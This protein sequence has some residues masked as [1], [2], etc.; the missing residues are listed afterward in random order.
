MLPFPGTIAIVRY[1]ETP[2]RP[3]S[4]HPP[5]GRGIPDSRLVLADQADIL[6]L[7]PRWRPGSANLEGLAAWHRA[8]GGGATLVVEG[9]RWT[10]IAAVDRVRLP[11]LPYDDFWNVP[12]LHALG[13]TRAIE[14]PGT[15]PFGTAL[16]D[17]D[18]TIIED[19]DYLADPEGVSLLPGAVAGLQSF[20]A[21]GVRL[22]VLT[23]QSGVG[24]GRISLAQL[25]MVH[26]RLRDLL[27]REGVTLD[28]IY[29]CIHPSDAGCA[30]RKPAVGLVQQAVA[31]LGFRL[32]QAVVAGDKPADLALARGLGVPAFLVATGSGLTTLTE[33][34][35][36]ADYVVDGLDELA[37]I[38]LHPAGLAVPAPCP[39]D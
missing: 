29:S 18:G 25:D 20:A 19:R 4:Q 30:C 22:V 32:D 26:D 1:P 16:L 39:T 11:G 15:P 13:S 17:R 2:G 38:C 6:L 28:G 35:I 9:S 36:Q 12:R 5:P 3:E 24:S 34:T 7:V 23:N 31:E 14:F 8:R 10:G 27:A 37:R 21:H 33:R